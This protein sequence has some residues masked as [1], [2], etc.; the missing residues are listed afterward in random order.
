[1]STDVSL[2][3]IA[4]LPIKP[5]ANECVYLLA[6]VLSGLGVSILCLGLSLPAIVDLVTLPEEP[7]SLVEA[8][9]VM[10]SSCQ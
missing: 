5:H 8:I 2:L 3:S 6:L 7:P 10:F 4:P 1:M 9:L